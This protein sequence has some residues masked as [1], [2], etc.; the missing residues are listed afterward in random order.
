METTAK[1]RL[2]EYLK[3][4]GIG[5]NKFES[6]AGLSIGYISKLRIEPSPTKLRSI[7]N[8]APDLNRE[9]LL[10][11]EGEMLI[12]KSVDIPG[13][14]R[15]SELSE[16]PP[17]ERGPAR[18]RMLPEVDFEFA[19]GPQLRINEREAVTRHWYLPDCTDC[20]AVVPVVGNSMLPN[21]PPG[22]YVALKRYNL[23]GDNPNTIPFGQIFGIV[24]EDEHTG[25]FHGHIKVLRR[26]K[27]PELAKSFWIA[28]SFNTAEFDDFDIA[29]QQV[30]SLWIVK[31]HIVSD[32][33]Y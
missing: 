32:T 29:I 28:H 22:C 18:P 2:I 11:G 17:M 14:V 13:V 4:K 26:H 15:A 19:A 31:Q 7:L 24:V 9:W 21:L 20:E 5:Q 8:A 25:E 23:T 1:Q 27:D 10:T 30:H 3:K 12:K 6:L 16:S 33:I